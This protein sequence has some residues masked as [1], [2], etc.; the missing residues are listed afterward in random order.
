MRIDISALS[1]N[2]VYHLMT[3]SIIPRPVAWV[4]TANKGPGYN[5]APFSYFNALSSEP[6]LVML[7]MGKKPDGSLKDTRS[8]ILNTKQLVIHIP[9][10]AQAAEVTESART[11]EYGDSELEHIDH[12]LVQEE[13]WPLP[14]LQDAPIA[15]LA[16]LYELHELGPN[17]QAVIYCEIKEF[18]IQD[19]CVIKE[20]NNRINIDATAVDALARLGGGE[21]ASLG[22]VFKI[23]RP[24]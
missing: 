8:N 6:P 9:N 5:L 4:L 12:P 16:E 2:N 23:E 20:E 3:Q 18:F 21:Y 13:G 15:M 17:K 11:L 19:E 22:E 1:A 14:R 24:K 10:T 7:S